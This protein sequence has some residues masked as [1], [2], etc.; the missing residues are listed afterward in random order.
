LKDTSTAVTIPPLYNETPLLML[1][2]AVTA[3]GPLALNIF[4]P[5]MPGLQSALATDYA[6]VQLTLTLYL[7]GTAVAQLF[8][9]SWSDRFG[10]RPVL[11][12][13]LA[14]FLIGSLA[15]AL[16]TSIGLLIGARIVQ[17]VGGC[18]GMVLGRAII[19]DLYPADVAASKIAYVT[20]AM[21][22]APMLAPTLGG[23]LDVWFSWRAGFVAVA[24]FAGVV[25]IATLR[26]LPETHRELQP[27]TGLGRM[28]IGFIGLLRSPLFCG[29]ALNSAFAS[30]IFFAFLAGAPYVMV[31]ILGRSPAQ[32]GLYFILVSI[33]YMAGNFIAARLSRR[34]GINRMLLISAALAVLATTLLV[35]LA[36][37]AVL[38][39]MAIFGPMM[40]VAIANGINL[41]NSISGAISVDPAMTG[42]ASGLAGFLQI[43]TG[44]LATFIVGQLQDNSQWPMVITMFAAAV[45]AFAALLLV[46]TTRNRSRRHGSGR[47]DA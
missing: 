4:I 40:L 38:T 43:A 27:L 8:L 33:C 22:V 1:L 31:E 13:G 16:A 15:S 42:A 44:A 7:L 29:Y 12:L 34:L 32:Y 35:L 23:F 25:L 18:A 30:A 39:P 5:S 45:L 21:V 14:L 3:I 2:I 11:L 26:L 37:N 47:A 19:R 36:M 20:M 46:L 28:F 41:P 17:A 9:G 24:A 10:R 6:T